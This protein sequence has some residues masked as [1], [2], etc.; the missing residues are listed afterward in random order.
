MLNARR[1]SSFRLIKIIEI[2]LLFNERSEHEL[3]QT[4]SIPT[5]KNIYINSTA[6]GI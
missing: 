3:L 1:F 5:Q 4:K 2:D 6:L